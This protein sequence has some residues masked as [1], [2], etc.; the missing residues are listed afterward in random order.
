MYKD[1]MFV[2]FPL[3]CQFVPPWQ[4]AC[5]HCVGFLL[6][7]LFSLVLDVPTFG[8]TFPLQDYDKTPTIKHPYYFGSSSDKRT[9][10]VKKGCSVR[11]WV[12]FCESIFLCEVN[13][14]IYNHGTWHTLQR[15]R[16][17]IIISQIS[18]YL[19]KYNDIF[20]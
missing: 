12:N 11:Q 20:L 3:S 14:L 16:M 4:Q 9:F 17:I 8:R 1:E 6:S 2:C 18:L 19:E 15:W 5:L 7:G 13:R 10:F